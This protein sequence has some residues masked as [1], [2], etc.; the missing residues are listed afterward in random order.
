MKTTSTDEKNNNIMIE[1]LDQM[2]N[3]ITIVEPSSM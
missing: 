3:K 1:A 2:I